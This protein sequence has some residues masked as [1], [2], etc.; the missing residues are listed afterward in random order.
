M[1]FFSTYNSPVR[2]HNLVFFWIKVHNLVDSSPHEYKVDMTA[3]H[4]VSFIIVKEKLNPI[5][6]KIYTFDKTKT[7]N[8]VNFTHVW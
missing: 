6:N 1:I 5:N 8:T 2:A 7:L 3:L 4:M